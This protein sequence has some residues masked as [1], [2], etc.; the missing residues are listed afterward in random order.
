MT[1]VLTSLGWF[2]VWGATAMVIGVVLAFAT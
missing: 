1:S 2:I